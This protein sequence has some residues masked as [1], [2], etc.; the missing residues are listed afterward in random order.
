MCH[1]EGQAKRDADALVPSDQLW[2]MLRMAAPSD[3]SG[4]RRDFLDDFCD[5]YADGQVC[6]VCEVTALHVHGHVIDSAGRGSGQG[7]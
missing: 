4:S 1:A 3:R 7:C 5:K 6:D 2:R